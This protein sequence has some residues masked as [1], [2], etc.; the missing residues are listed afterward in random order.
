MNVVITLSLSP[1]KNQTVTFVMNDS[2]QL[3]LLK[4]DFIVSQEWVYR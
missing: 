4:T 1:T 2:D 3:S